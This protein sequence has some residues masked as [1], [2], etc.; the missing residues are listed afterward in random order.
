MLDVDISYCR[1]CCA[2]CEYPAKLT[3][4]ASLAELSL[5]HLRDAWRV[6]DYLMMD[7]TPL[8]E[9]TAQRVMRGSVADVAG[10]GLPD[11]HTRSVVLFGAA[12]SLARLQP[13]PASGAQLRDSRHSHGVADRGSVGPTPRHSAR[14]RRRL[15]VG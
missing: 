5:P 1:Q 8:A 9:D 4:S 11:E 2:F 7:A 14:K 6:A 13:P 15:L 3:I 12:A 10:L